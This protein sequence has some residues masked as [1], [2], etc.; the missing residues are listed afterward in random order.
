MNYIEEVTKDIVPNTFDSFANEIE[1]DPRGTLT[2]V[3]G[4]LQ[5]HYVRYGNDWTGRGVVGDSTQEAAI[6]GLE[7]VRAECLARLEGEENQ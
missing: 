1:C 5:A 4:M 2:R 3:E 7:A 6:A